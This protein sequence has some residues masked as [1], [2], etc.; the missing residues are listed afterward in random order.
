MTLEALHGVAK[1]FG[2]RQILHGLDLDVGSGARIGVIGPNGG[3]KSTMLRLLAGLEEP[4][5]GDVVRRRGVAHLPQQ[6]PGT[7]APHSRPSARLGPTW[8]RSR[9]TWPP[10]PHGSAHPRPP[11][12][13]A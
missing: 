11:P 6:V 4:D 9:P 1:S 2:A 8:P 7:P 12:T 3:G 13:S 10:S 5:R